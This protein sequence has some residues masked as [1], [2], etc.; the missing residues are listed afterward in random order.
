MS[1]R[2]VQALAYLCTSFFYGTIISGVEPNNTHVVQ[3][4]TVLRKQ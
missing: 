4:L 1:K 3:H 2:S